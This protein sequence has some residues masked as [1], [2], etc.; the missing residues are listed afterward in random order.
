L[1]AAA[2]AYT[3]SGVTVN[4]PHPATAGA[5]L[6]TLVILVSAATAV[7]A[8]PVQVFA[9]GALHFCQLGNGLRV[10]VKE[11]HSAPVVAVNVVIRA[12]TRCETAQNNG[13]AHFLEHMIFRAARGGGEDS[14]AGP[15]EAVGGVVNG[16]TL[17]DFTYFRAVTAPPHL[18]LA[19]SALARALLHPAFS[20]QAVFAERVIV[21][22]ELRQVADDPEAAAWARA[23]AFAYGDHPYA[24]PIGGTEQSLVRINADLLAGFHRRW[25]VPDDASLVI[26]GDVDP[27]VARDAAASAFGAWAAT[28]AGHP[29]PSPPPPAPQLPR[30]HVETRDLPQAT[31]LMAF[32]APGISAPREVCAMDLLLTILSE[33]YTARLKRALVETGI[34]DEVSADFLTQEMPGLFAIRATCAPQRLAQARRALADEILRLRREPVTDG[35]FAKAQRRLAYSYVFANETVEDQAATLGFYEAI[36]TYEFAVAYLDQVRS[37]TAA[38]VLAAARKHLDPERA[39]WVAIAPPAAPEVLRAQGADR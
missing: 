20:N 9:P 11:D 8:A 19:L 35:E 2:D 34:A 21:L 29:A 12:G 4:H 6:L 22:S 7:A 32:R 24:L 33:G 13:I 39:V 3:M 31:V 10:V 25:Y 26:V 14:L 28:G 5:R 38:E 1:T 18:P 16:G 36:A 30:T 17:R 15:I 27:A 23:F 37:L